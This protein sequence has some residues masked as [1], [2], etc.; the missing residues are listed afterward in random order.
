MNKNNTKRNIKPTK[1]H[2]DVNL[3]IFLVSNRPEKRIIE[4]FK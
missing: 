3:F 4:E 2:W 1:N